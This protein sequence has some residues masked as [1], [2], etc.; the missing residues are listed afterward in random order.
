MDVIKYRYGYDSEG[1]LIDVNTLSRDCKDFQL[2]TCL[3]CGRSLLPILGEKRRKHF[4]HKADIEINCSPETYLHKLAKETFFEVYSECLEHKKEFN[5]ALNMEKECNF[6]KKDFNFTCFLGEG[7][8][9]FD[10]TQY[11]KEITLEKREDNFIPDLLLF[12]NR[13]DKIFIEIAVTHIATQEKRQSK[14]RIIELQIKEEADIETIKSCFLCEDDRINFFNFTKVSQA[15]FCSGDC[16]NGLKVNAACPVLYKIFII[17]KNGKSYFDDQASLER[18][19]EVA[20]SPNVSYWEFIV[21]SGYTSI[22]QECREIYKKKILESFYQNRP[23]KNCFLCRY[24]GDN[25]SS[26]EG[27]IYCRFLK[28]A[29]NSNMAATCSYYRPDPKVFPDFDD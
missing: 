5:I 3:S 21:L 25:F 19:R 4:R 20:K 1:K 18:V 27:S 12:N 23:I 26:Q 14:Y 28:T 29:G 24:H 16:Y 15:N 11:F 13:G 7:Q 10:L 8:C 9:K 17:Y 6:Y 22:I 2:F